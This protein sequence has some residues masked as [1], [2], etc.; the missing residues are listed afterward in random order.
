MRRYDILEEPGG[1]CPVPD[2]KE[3]AW[4]GWVKLEDH[5]ARAAELEAERDRCR[6]SLNR[7]KC[8]LSVT[9]VPGDEWV[10]SL[11]GEIFAIA[12]RALAVH[13][14]EGHPG[15]HPPRKPMEGGFSLDKFLSGVSKEDAEALCEMFD[16][17][18]A[19]K[20]LNGWTPVAS[21]PE[22]GHYLTFGSPYGIYPMAFTGHAWF[23]H[24]RGE[25][26]THWMS[27]PAPP[28]ISKEAM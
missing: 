16:R 4:G 17:V 1:C 23:S 3:C 6:E 22:P 10:K 25:K 28:N 26:P 2:L 21:P 14:F 24:G 11:H 12:T 15:L 8:K 20:A 5:E 13:A 9:D 19:E 7:I 18:D 27:L